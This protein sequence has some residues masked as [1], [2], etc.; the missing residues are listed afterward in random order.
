MKL[1]IMTLDAV[2]YVKANITD[3]AK[4]YQPDWSPEIWLTSKLG[5]PAFVE[6]TEL[7]DFDDF[8]LL[9]NDH[10]PSDTDVYNIK[11]FYK[12][13]IDINDSFASD[14]R[15]WAGLAHTVFYQYM[16]ERWPN[17]NT[18]EAILNHFFFNM[19]APR[20]YM[21][22]TL[23]RLWWYGKKTYMP[24]RENPFEILDF[25][26][27][28]INGFGFTLFGS[29][30]SN[31]ERTLNV[32]FDAVFDYE[33]ISENK[34]KRA[35]FNDTIQYM[36]ALCGI[37]TIDACDA[38]FVKGKVLNYLQVRNGEILAEDK[39]NKLNNVKKTGIEKLDNIIAAL[40]S[41]GGHGSTSSI[42]KA[43]EE[44]TQQKMS[45]ATR[46]YITKSL[47]DYAPSGDSSKGNPIFHKTSTSFFS[48]G[49]RLSNNY[50]IKDNLVTRIDFVRKQIEELDSTDKMAYNLVSAMRNEKFTLEDILVFVPQLA[51]MHPEMQEPKKV[52]KA[53]IVNLK[54][55]GIIE[56]V[57]SNTF[58]KAY[59][60][61]IN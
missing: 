2:A 19:S 14:E 10:N 4:Y 49:W 42:I 59:N 29:N 45:M 58:R 12:K 54:Q 9:I 13:L 24:E 47:S 15:L 61:R 48:N 38:D 23:A 46:N 6:V 37:Y 11:L 1:K 28:D 35:L 22:N 43:Y 36:N 33:R 25:M 27:K 39:Y 30:W 52:I 44:I 5:K 20:C 56:E 55:K 26:A 40:N 16:M 17:K 41:I 18:P 50:L 34:V 8:E 3:L 7:G 51:Q 53:S 21:V 31:S 60:I 32:F 57:E